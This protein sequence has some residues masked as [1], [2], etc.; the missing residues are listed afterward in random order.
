MDY[1]KDNMQPLLIGAV[2]GAVLLFAVQYVMKMRETKNDG[3][4]LR[5]SANQNPGLYGS[6]VNATGAALGISEYES[7]Q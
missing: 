5:G 6:S 4:I 2:I 7:R 1:V 3:F